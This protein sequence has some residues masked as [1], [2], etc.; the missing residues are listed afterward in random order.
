[1]IRENPNPC[2]LRSK[3]NLETGV[4][5]IMVSQRP[6]LRLKGNSKNMKLQRLAFLSVLLV[7]TAGL[8]IAQASPAP[9]N[10]SDPKAKSMPATSMAMGD[11][12]VAHPFWT[13][14]GMPEAKGTSVLRISGLTTS[15]DGHSRNDFAFH[16]ETGLTDRVGF[17]LRN[18]E[19]TTDPFTETMFQYAA[20][21]S[22]DGMS[23]ISPLIEFEF[24]TRG[25]TEGGVK[26]MIGFSSTLT[27]TRAAINQ[28]LHYEPRTKMFEGSIA[29]V[30][31]HSKGFYPVFELLGNAGQGMPTVLNLLAGPKF[32]VSSNSIVGLAYES[33]ISASKDFGS[34]FILQLETKW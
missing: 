30:C 21:R 8:A 6:P 12:E 5:Q 10:M 27:M 1:M 34:K 20:I 32:K 2:S 16:Y 11:E 23:G 22:K 29:Y 31:E 4:S 7:T 19:F 3:V 9:M 33:P 13:H 24:P 26:T 28:V 15:A 17:H 18:D 25:G 14:M